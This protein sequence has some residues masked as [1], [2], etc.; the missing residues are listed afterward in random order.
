MTRYDKRV[1]ALAIGLAALAERV[2][3]DDVWPIHGVSGTAQDAKFQNVGDQYKEKRGQKPDRMTKASHF[4]RSPE[5]R[6]NAGCVP[7]P[8]NEDQ[9]NC[10]GC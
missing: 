1:Q 4:H 6:H 2:V 10:H 3:R 7:L 8:I 9:C 5:L